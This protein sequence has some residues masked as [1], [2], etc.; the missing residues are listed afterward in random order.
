M[1]R[2]KPDTARTKKFIE[3]EWRAERAKKSPLIQSLED[4]IKIPN[5]SPAF[6]ANWADSGHADAAAKLLLDSVETLKRRWIGRGVKSNDIRAEILGGRDRPV[7]NEAGE[8]RTPALL[9]KIPATGYAAA[10]TILIYGHMDKQP[11]MNPWS[12]GFGPRTPVVKNGRLYGR[13]SADDGYALFCALSAVAALREQN[14]PHARILVL[15][16]G[17]EES[18]GA[19]IAWYLHTLR[20]RL[21]HISLVLCLDSGAGD[22]ERL[23]LTTSLRGL[24]GGILKVEV[25]SGPVHSGAASGVAPSPFRIMRLLLSRLEDEKS[26]FVKPKDFRTTIPT[27]VRSDATKTAAI[28]GERV[29]SDFPFRHNVRPAVD[30]GAELLLNRTWRAQLSVTGVTGMP[31]AATAGNVILPFVEAK[32]SLRLP[33]TI[34]SA[35]AAIS[36]K[37]LLEQDPPYNARVSFVPENVMAGW[38]APRRKAWLRNVVRDASLAFFGKDALNCGEGGSIDFMNA[39]SKAYPQAQLLVTGVL[40]P[41]SNAHGADEALHLDMTRKLTMCVAHILAAHAVRR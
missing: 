25:L 17:R 6:E 22:Y 31:A 32:L 10:D 34:D 8:R 13:G 38:R 30:D 23:W 37:K 18:D 28:L 4:F 40:G 5:L 16:E 14:I 35:N 1:L 11:E 29:Y 3:E 15:I 41:H 12:P 39:L 20:E 7:Y 24:A 26:G 2:T 36:L 33:P 9:V 27:A 19:D 21:G